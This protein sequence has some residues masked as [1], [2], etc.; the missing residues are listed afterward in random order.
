MNRQQMLAWA[1]AHAEGAVDT[2]PD[3][4]SSLSSRLLRFRWRGAPT[5]AVDS[6]ADGKTRINSVVDGLAYA[7]SQ[8]AGIDKT[9]NVVVGVSSAAQTESFREQLDAVGTMAHAVGTGVTIR[10]WTVSAS[11][12]LTELPVQAAQFSTSSP[13]RWAEMLTR[14]AETA[15]DGLAHDLLASA[16]CPAL[17]LY[18]KLS[19]KD[20]SQPWQLRLD[21]LDIGRVGPNAGVLR[22]ASRDITAPRE[23]RVTWLKVI[24]GDPW[25]FKHDNLAGTVAKIIELSGCWTK[26]GLGVLQHQQAEHALEAHILSGRVPLTVSG[27]LLRPAIPADDGALRVAQFPTL[28][29]D[30]TRPARYL[31]VLLRDDDG[32]PWAIELKDQDAGG[33]HG[34]Y[35]RHGITQAVLYRHYI[36]SVDALDAWFRDR[37]LA[38]TQC[39]A[40]LAFPRAAAGTEKSIES[41]ALLAS[42]FD[43]EVVQFDRP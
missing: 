6:D 35:L 43:V 31:D 28:W 32:R 15:V 12:E 16:A 21:G 36:R 10:L 23:P 42:Y 7:L 5:V 11:N 39:G 26:A 19:S 40:A 3:R 22:L 2:K 17:A 13:T 25:P 20:E 27:A 8:P 37:G 1:T 38:R 34:S 4:R 24:G 30:V 33:G 14:A 9:L 29:G 18:P 41:L